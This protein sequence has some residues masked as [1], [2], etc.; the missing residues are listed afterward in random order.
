MFDS[1]TPEF[2]NMPLVQYYIGVMLTF[3]PWARCYERAGFKVW[4]VVLLGIPYLGL[5]LVAGILACR[6]W[7]AQVNPEVKS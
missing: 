2:F 3:I 4:F 6:R 5:I 1:L 7:P